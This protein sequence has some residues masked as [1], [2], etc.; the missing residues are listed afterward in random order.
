MTDNQL[1]SEGMPAVCESDNQIDA[2][3][4]P[5]ESEVTKQSNEDMAKMM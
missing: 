4:L 1:N 3:G 5:A 2:Q